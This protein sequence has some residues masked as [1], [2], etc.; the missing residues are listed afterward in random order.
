MGN[1]R[2]K[3]GH[4]ALLTFWLAIRETEREECRSIGAKRQLT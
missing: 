3:K 1:K 4:N 2:E